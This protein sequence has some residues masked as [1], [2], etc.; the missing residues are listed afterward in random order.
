M[1]PN[2]LVPSVDLDLQIVASSDSRV[3]FSK[4]PL[5]NLWGTELSP[6]TAAVPTN[7][8]QD[9]WKSWIEAKKESG[10]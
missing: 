8:T 9:Q 5:V 10:V 6:G 2:Y 3:V 1:N 7:A 4:Q